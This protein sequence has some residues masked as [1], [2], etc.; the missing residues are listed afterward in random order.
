ML[1]LAVADEVNDKTNASPLSVGAWFI[2]KNA[3]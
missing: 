2:E 3:G 1:N